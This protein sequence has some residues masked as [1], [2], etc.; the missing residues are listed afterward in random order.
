[1]KKIPAL[2]IA[3]LLLSGWG[4]SGYCQDGSFSGMD[5]DSIDQPG[6]GVVR[7]IFPGLNEDESPDGGRAVKAEEPEDTVVEDS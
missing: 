1:M 7:D 3:C 5:D 2:I 4:I 6:D